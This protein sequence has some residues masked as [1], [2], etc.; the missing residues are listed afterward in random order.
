MLTRAGMPRRRLDILVRWLAA[1][2]VQKRLVLMQDEQLDDSWVLPS[3]QGEYPGRAVLDEPLLHRRRERTFLVLATLFVTATAATVIL[4]TSRV[5]D[6]SYAIASVF[7]EI[8]LPFELALPFGV[9]A[10]PIALFAATLVC[11]LYGR[12]RANALVLMG[13]VA[14]LA[15]S[16]L[17]YA[18][19]VLDG[20][21]ASLGSA[22]AF[23]A[24]YLVAHLSNLII[25]DAL[26]HRMNGRHPVLRKTL[27]TLLAQIGG[28]AAFAFAAYAYAM[29]VAGEAPAVASW[30]A[31]LALTSALFVAAVAL[32]DLIPFAIA[33]RTLKNYLRV[34]TEAD[35]DEVIELARPQPPAFIIH[36]PVHPS[37][38]LRTTGERRFFTEGDEA[39]ELR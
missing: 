35:E 8:A 38:N 24:C 39:S 26:H 7:P 9:L 19:D 33:Q 6:I 29:Y 17:M 13:L 12:R 31:S 3:R 5:I 36:A 4:G 1:R 25:F 27:S 18:V 16:G 11:E 22:L 32:V 28:W 21:D 10:F 15:L 37:L 2:L 34:V 30:I 23:T 14:S 20:T